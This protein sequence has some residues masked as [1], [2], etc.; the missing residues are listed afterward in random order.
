MISTDFLWPRERCLLPGTVWAQRGEGTGPGGEQKTGSH[1][2]PTSRAAVIRMS[3]TPTL[4]CHAGPSPEVA[5]YAYNER[6]R[7][8]RFT[9]EETDSLRLCHRGVMPGQEVAG[10]CESEVHVFS[11]GSPCLPGCHDNSVTYRPCLCCSLFIDGQTEAWRAQETQ[12]H[13]DG[14]VVDAGL[15]PGPVFILST[16]HEI[17][18]PYLDTPPPPSLG[19]RSVTRRGYE[20]VPWV[21]M[22]NRWEA[23]LLEGSRRVKLQ[24]VRR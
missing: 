1:Q 12:A 20:G 5:S 7:H 8:P 9:G 22:R 21:G 11:T 15:A 13:M 17:S 6:C 3:W 2:D 18:H 16:T 10:L 19:S 4:G 24:S 14:Y 23:W